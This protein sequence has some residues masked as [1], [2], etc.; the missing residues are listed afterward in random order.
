MSHY[1][2]THNSSGEATF[3]AKI[4]PSQAEIQTPFGTQNILFTTWN[5]PI[6]L[7]TEADIDQYSKDR[8]EGLGHKICPE[9]GSAAAIISLPPKAES[10][11]H[12]TMTLD[13]IYILE[14]SL[15]LH[16][17]SG[18]K[19][20]LKAGDSVVQRAGMHKWVNVSENDGWAKMLGF[21]QPVVDPVEVGGKKLGTEFVMP[22]Q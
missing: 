1:V 15:E 16:L 3:S 4:S 19:R 14:G 18:E 5:S 7:S 6:N 12:R 22:R 8:S 21:T 20:T 17:D 2:T 13:V 11:F 9:N 10:P